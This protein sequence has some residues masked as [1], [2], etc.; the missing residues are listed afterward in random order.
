MTASDRP[1]SKRAWL[2][3]RAAVARAADSRGLGPDTITANIDAFAR[4]IGLDRLETDIFR[5]VFLTDHEDEFGR[6]CSS[7]IETRRLDSR[8]LV[9]LAIGQAASDISAR[10]ARGSLVSLGLIKVSG[11]AASRFAWSVAYRLLHVLQPP[12]DGLADIERGLIG[13]PMP[14]QLDSEDF[15][16][17]ARER[18]F[19]I[20]L[21]RAAVAGG[22]K[23]I[24]ILLHGGPGTGK[25]EFCKL[26]AARS[27]CDLFAIGE[28]DEEGDEPSRHER[29]DALRLADR[30]A[31]RRGRAVLLFDEMEDILQYGERYA[32]GFRRVR[33]SGSKVFFN[34]LLEHNAVPVLW[35]ANAIDE[36]DPAFLRRM[37]FILE[38]KPL[39]VAARAQLWS[40]LARQHGLQ[41]PPTEASALARRHKIAPSLMSGAVHAVAMARGTVED[42]EFVVAKLAR[43]VCGGAK[44][45]PPTQAFG[46]LPELV[47]A[48]SDLVA[49]ESACA[50]L[51][52]GRDISLCLYGPPGTGKS[53]F[54][55][56]LA[57]V[58]GLDPLVKRGSDL[59]SMW[60]GE[61][62]QRIAEAF[63]EAR[64]DERF[65][66][67]DEAEA[68]LWS[69]GTARHSWEV[70][71]VNELLSA[72]EAHPL[73]FACTTNHLGMIDPAA[74]RRFVFKVKF[75]FLSEA[76]AV[77]AYRRFCCHEPPAGL[78]DLATLTPGDFAAVA[79]KLR[80][81][82][83]AQA[84]DAAILRMLEQEVAVK[85]LPAR[86]IGF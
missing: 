52:T 37:T 6:L 63:E 26:I 16:H 28:V 31:S 13:A 80:L 61:T 39:P 69:R 19:A 24:N 73:P 25:S 65:L 1:L 53:A 11:D 42:V 84:T 68:F 20:R 72:M 23:G 47:N 30:L 82:G 44:P 75:D 59:L 48:D 43:P 71:M 57:A 49:L 45:E 55:R 35:T 74:L 7:I 22:Q 8:G 14:A 58:M 76:Q 12:T 40:G 41:L 34:R 64:Q 27:G 70:S 83:P 15:A 33:R 51:K 81:L 3:L 29:V 4:A 66:I 2:R 50:R 77:E 60:I 54:A 36:F 86:R 62:E 38:M 21:L 10:L 32:T 67:I 9:A 5:F 79:K 46:F 78:R 17:V 85:G 56:H 18:D